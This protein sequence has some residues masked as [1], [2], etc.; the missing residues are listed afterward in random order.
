MSDLNIYIQVIISL[1]IASP[2]KRKTSLGSRA[3]EIRVL[4]F[5]G[6]VQASSKERRDFLVLFQH[7]VLTALKLWIIITL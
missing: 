5:D 7:V 6:N 2:G 4:L 1:P 3:F